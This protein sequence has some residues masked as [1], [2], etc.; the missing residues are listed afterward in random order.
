MS[1]VTNVLI[2]ASWERDAMD[3]LTNSAR[4]W[5]HTAPWRGYFGSISRQPAAEYW[6]DDGKWPECDVWAGAFN[7]LNRPGL[8]AELQELPWEKPASVQV[9]I[10]GQDDDCWGLWMFVDGRLVEV[11]LPGAVRLPL[12]ANVRAQG[13]FVDADV[14][15]LLRR[16]PPTSTSVPCNARVYGTGGA[17]HF[18]IYA[19]GHE[20]AV[21][22]ILPVAGNTAV[23]SAQ[24]AAVA[25]LRE[26]FGVGYDIVWRFERNGEGWWGDIATATA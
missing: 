13:E 12:K 2:L 18:V 23:E 25:T 17:W 4:R 19:D 3:A 1:N 21:A 16:P 8:L 9:L 15:M 14:G 24:A 20:T 10:R 6:G 5:D 26:R 11:D 7:N 22:G